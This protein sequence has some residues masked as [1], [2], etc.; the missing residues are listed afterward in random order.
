MKNAQGDVVQIRSVWGTAVVEYEYDAWGN[1]LS[2]DGLYADTLGDKNPI[3]YRSYYYD[4][5]TGFYYLQSRYYDPQ[6]RR[7]ISADDPGMLGSTDTFLSYNLYAY[8]ENNPVNHIDPTGHVVVVLS[9]TFGGA[10]YIG[11]SLAAYYL[12]DFQGNQGIIL[13]AAMA[14]GIAGVGKMLSVGVYWK[15][16][17]I[18]DFANSTVVSHTIGIVK[19]VTFGVDVDKRKNTSLAGVEL[20]LFEASLGYL[21]TAAGKSI[22]IKSKNKHYLWQIYDFIV[23]IIN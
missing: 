8:C 1:I 18:D 10:L 9:A 3:R 14:F 11:F 21:Y 5:E 17:T 6:V 23:D 2:I 7:F 16:K 13:S 19:S 20:G 22:Y 12:F 15:Y 4:H